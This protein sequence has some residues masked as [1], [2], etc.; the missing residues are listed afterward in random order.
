M[1]E[2]SPCLPHGLW[3]ATDLAQRRFRCTPCPRLAASCR[4]ANASFSQD[5]PQQTTPFGCVLQSA[6]G[7]GKDAIVGARPPLGGHVSQRASVD[8]L[9]MV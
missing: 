8:V 1:S 6:I 5:A 4:T 3:G 7:V 9:M 2:D